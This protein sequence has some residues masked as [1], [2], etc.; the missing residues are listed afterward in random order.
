MHSSSDYIESKPSIQLKI[1]DTKKVF[2]FKLVLGVLLAFL[3]LVGL[4]ISGYS[5]PENTRNFDT[6][7]EITT[8]SQLKGSTHTHG[9]L[10][11]SHPHDAKHL[12]EGH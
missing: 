11:H 1:K 8:Q 10:T 4:K 2:F 12:H 3:L 7:K 9:G 5:T 6:S